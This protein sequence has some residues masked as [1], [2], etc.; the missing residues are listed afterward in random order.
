MLRLLQASSQLGSASGAG[1]AADGADRAASAGGGGQ[2]P[3]TGGGGQPPLHCRHG[4]T[5]DA[6]SHGPGQEAGEDYL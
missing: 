4:A 6:R 2:P 5:S 3:E 1:S